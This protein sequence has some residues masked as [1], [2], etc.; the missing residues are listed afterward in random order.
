MRLDQAVAA[1]FPEISRRKAR[2]LI[3]AGRVLVNQRR[4]SVASREVGSDDHIAVATELPQIAVLALRDEWIAVDK[5][6]G[7]PTQPERD[8]RRLSLEEILRIEHKNIWLV[9]RL[10]TPTSGVVVF[11]RTQAAAGGLSRLFAGGEIRKT[12][13]AACTPPLEKERTIDTP[14]AG[15]DALTI[16]RPLHGGLVEVDLRTGRTHQIRIHLAS[17]GHPIDGDRRYGGAP[18]PRLMLHAWKLQ[19][20]LFG[21]IVAP[22]PAGFG[23]ARVPSPASGA[24]KNRA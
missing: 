23:G 1:R 24:G 12:Y 21:E 7:M 8:R 22:V 10:D 18:A 6:A 20:E 4:V 14:I 16:V 19:H 15:K 2:E 17:I 9:H 11:A 13:L 3:A 5:P